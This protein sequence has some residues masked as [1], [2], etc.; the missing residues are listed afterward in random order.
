MKD[1]AYYKRL[2]TVENKLID[3][4]NELECKFGL[5]GFSERISR[6]NNKAPQLK[7]LAQLDIISEF[8]EALIEIDDSEEVEIEFEIT[9]EI[10][11]TDEIR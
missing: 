3:S 2:R 1:T 10:I 8:L 5:S 4:L 11:K 9:E 7:S 6:I